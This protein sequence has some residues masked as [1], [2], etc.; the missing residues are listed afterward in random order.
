MKA[1]SLHTFAPVVLTLENQ[2]EVDALYALLNHNGLTNAAGLD[3]DAFKVLKPFASGMALET[4]WNGI[5][6]WLSKYRRAFTA[7]PAPSISPVDEND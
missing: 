3:P 7:A 5:T 1:A 4:N 2:Q 6:A